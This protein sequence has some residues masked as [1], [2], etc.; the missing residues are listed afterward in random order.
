MHII[1]TINALYLN[2]F[3]ISTSH[4][5]LSLHVLHPLEHLVHLKIGSISYK[6]DLFE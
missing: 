5:V 2:S 1:F 6:P 3:E 4:G